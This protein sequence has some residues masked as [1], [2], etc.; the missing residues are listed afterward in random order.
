M[1]SYAL[2]QTID[3]A[4]TLLHYFDIP[5]PGDMQGRS[6]HSVLETGAAIREVLIR[7]YTAI[8]CLIFKAIRSSNPSSRIRK[9][10]PA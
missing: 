6:L 4:P 9:W 10:K 2:V 1:R 5:V 8:C 3:L 7:S